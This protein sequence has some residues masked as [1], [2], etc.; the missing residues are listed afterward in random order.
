VDGAERISDTIQR[1]ELSHGYNLLTFNVIYRWFP[2]GERDASWLGRIQP[3]GGAGVGM[4]L[5]HV[6]AKINGVKTWE[7]Q[8]TGP[9]LQGFVGLNIDVILFVSVFGEY[10]IT[11]A[12]VTAD[13]QDGGTISIIP[14]TNHFVFGV[15]LRF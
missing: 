8:S 10:K 3:Y 7:Y 5:P 14:V 4:T 12:D 6:E 15:S 9:A 2:K 11:Y 1:F 13:L